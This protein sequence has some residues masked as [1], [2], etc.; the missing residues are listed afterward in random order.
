MKHN[1]IQIYIIGIDLLRLFI[2]YSPIPAKY[3]DS[4]GNIIRFI[5]DSADINSWS[6]GDDPTKE[7]E[8]NTMLGLRAFTNLFDIREGSDLI[9]REASKVLTENKKIFKL[10]RYENISFN[11]ISLSLFCFLLDR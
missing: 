9:R 7:L 5:I 6:T 11:I 3:E 8:T 1:F 10:M 4:N 2:L